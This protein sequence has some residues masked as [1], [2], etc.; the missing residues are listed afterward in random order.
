MT[1]PNN[2]SAH[3]AADYDTVIEATIPYHGS[4][5]QEALRFTRANLPAPSLWLDTGCG[6]GTLVEQ[7]V[8]TF[9][10]TRFV[11]ADPSE[12]MLE[13][14]RL[15][16]GAT[17]GRVWFLPPSGSERL[18]VGERRF[19]VVTAIQCH[20]YLDANGRRAAVATCHRALR[21]G[22]LF[23]AFENIRPSPPPATGFAMKYWKAYQLEMGRA[24]EVVEAQL[25]RFDREYFPIT[26]DAHLELL[27]EVGFETVGLLWYSYM[28]AGVFGLKEQSPH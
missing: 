21:G 11:L 25:A 5:L 22:G 20:H 28:Q 13:Q 4:F 10:A 24:P 16:L 18:N 19:D 8:K 7:A 26:V 3:R 15:K 6:T 2:A 12:A 17:G 1:T 23:I 27:R 14:A 9:P